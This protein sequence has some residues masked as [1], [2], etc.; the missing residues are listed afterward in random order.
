[1]NIIK[2][3]NKHL[4]L[5]GLILGFVLFNLAFYL[6]ITR[7]YIN[8]TSP[9][10]Q[11]KSVEVHKFLPFDENS[12]IV[13]INSTTKLTGD[14]PKID[15]AAA[16]FPVFSAFVYSLY[17]ENSVEMQNKEFTSSSALQYRNTRGAYKAIVD[18]DVDIIMV[19]R[20]SKEQLQYAES[21]G[22]ELKFV[23]IGYDAF[24]FLVNKNNPVDNV[25]LQ[26]IEHIYTGKIKNWK[27]VG[28]DNR[29]IQAL[30]RNQGSGSQTKML[31]VMNNKKIKK[32]IRGYF[33]SPI[34]FSFRYYVEGLVGNGKVKM[35][36]INGAYPDKNNIAN[37][38]YP[39]VG[40]IVLV[41]AANNSNPNIQKLID[42]AVSE[43]GQ[44]IV[45]QS[46]YVPL[47]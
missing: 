6:E 29:F 19:A 28:G 31:K 33:G 20:P 32:T 46:G 17:P 34:G 1:M 13:K 37:G 9:E 25:S 36:S 27:E 4:I 45:E 8:E 21:H 47:K 44:K 11:V 39:L 2:K 41:Y 30:T 15:G 24:V 14:L 43:D 3:Y 16:L 18:G 42:W 12:Q 35:L 10:M 40:E 22:V 38:K 23:P 5:I 7:R 26:E